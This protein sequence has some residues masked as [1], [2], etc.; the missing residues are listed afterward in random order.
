MAL[1]RRPKIG[2]VAAVSETRYHIDYDWWK[3][4]N[5]DLRV[6][7]QSHLCSE[8]QQVF[9]AYTGKDVVDWIDPRTAEVRQVDGLEHTL[10]SH[11]SLQPDYISS[12]TS[13]VDAVFRV[14]LA[15]GNYPMTAD[16]MARQL[17]RPADTIERTLSGGRIY[18]G[19]RPFAG[20]GEAED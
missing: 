19:I 11:C 2:K 1:H 9:S 10:H 5:R 17:G 13:L 7:L 6:Y 12:H 20:E 3:G 18:K 8:H 16:E 15:N 14:F 4:A